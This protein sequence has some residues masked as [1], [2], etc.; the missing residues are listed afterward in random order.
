MAGSYGLSEEYRDKAPIEV[1]RAP[2]DRRVLLGEMVLVSEATQEDRL[3]YPDRVAAEGIHSILVAPLIGKTGTIGLLRAYRGTGQQFSE[4]DKA[5]LAAI[6]SEGAVAI[7]NAQAYRMLATL[8]RQKSDFVRI[9]THELR[10]PVGV[11]TSVLRLLE[12]GYVG[13]LTPSQA[14]LVARAQRRMEFL[15]TLVDD[16]L[17]LAAGKADVVAAAERGPVSLSG[18]AE[19]VYARFGP[20]AQ[21]KGLSLSLESTDGQLHVWGERSELDRILNNLVGNAV[22]YTAQGEVRLSL[23][24]DDRTARFVVSDNGIGIPQDA[25]PH[26]FEEFYR[27]PNARL[28]ERAGTGLG[29]SIVKNLVDRYG[30]AL[31]VTSVEG[32]GTTFTLTL[33]LIEPPPG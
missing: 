5:F 24:R 26:L 19:E 29:L 14:D 16:L 3:R 11:A 9:V 33:P 23:A 21:A 18:V 22:K 17:D 27:A 13:E 2:L 15:Q 8:D 4:D 28:A 12:Q 32:Q 30:G 31:D 1:A 25:L 20:P 10:S 6:A 7:E